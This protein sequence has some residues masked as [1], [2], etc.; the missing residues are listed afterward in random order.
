MEALKTAC[1][2]CGGKLTGV[3]GGETTEHCEEHFVQGSLLGLVLCFDCMR[4]LSV[5]AVHDI[6]ERVSALLIDCAVRK[7]TAGCLER[8]D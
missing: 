2:H 8:T 6:P 3:Y 4:V 5:S 1:P 7:H